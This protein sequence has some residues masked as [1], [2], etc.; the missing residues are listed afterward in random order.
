MNKY[1]PIF[2]STVCIYGGINLSLSPYN[3]EAISAPIIAQNRNVNGRNVREVRYPQKGG[4][5]FQQQADGSWVETNS[6]GRFTFREENR[7]DW[8]VYLIKSDGLPIQL[9]L[10]RR[11]VIW[12]GQGKLYDI[13]GAYQTVST[14]GYNVTEVRYPQKGGGVFQQ[15]ANGSWVETNSDGRFT[16]REQNRDAWSV[17]LIKS[18][19]LPIQLDLHRREVIWRGQG[20]LYDIISSSD[21]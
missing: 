10:H 3:V 4:G 5:F 20:K 13:E 18:D 19:G 12:R 15:Q 16:F 21:N 8:S 11:E 1:L 2:L 7:D 17:Y 14:N 6:D 9:D